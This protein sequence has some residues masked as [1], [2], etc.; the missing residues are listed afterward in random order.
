MSL[1]FIYS[2][3]NNIGTG[4]RGGNTGNDADLVLACDREDTDLQGG[5]FFLFSSHNTLPFL[6]KPSPGNPARVL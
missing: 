2:R 1:S 6:A 4:H 5:L 3:T